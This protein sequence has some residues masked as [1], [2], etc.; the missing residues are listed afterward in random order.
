M[1][2]R[3]QKRTHCQQHEMKWKNGMPIAMALWI[4]AVS[5]GTVCAG[6]V[7]ARVDTSYCFGDYTGPCSPSPPRADNNPKRGG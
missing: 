1:P 2:T 6:E 4:T 3:H 5:A 7:T